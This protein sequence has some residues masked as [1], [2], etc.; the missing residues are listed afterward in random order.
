MYAGE[1]WLKNNKGA[2]YF[3]FSTVELDASFVADLAGTVCIFIG[4]LSFNNSSLYDAYWSAAPIFI[5]CYW[6]GDRGFDDLA[7]SPGF[8]RKC[9]VFMVMFVWGNRL[10]WNWA[11]SW[12]GFHH[13]DWRYVEVFQK[14]TKNYFRYWAESFGG[15]HLFPT[16]IVFAAMLP[17]YWVLHDH[18][19]EQV[20]PAEALCPISKIILR[21]FLKDFYVP[22]V[23]VVKPR[24][25][26]C[27]VPC[28]SIPPHKHD[29]EDHAFAVKPWAVRQVVKPSVPEPVTRNEDGRR[30]P[31]R[32]VKAGVVERQGT[33][34][35]THG[36][37]QVRN[38]G[39]VQFNSGKLKVSSTLVVLQPP[40][41]SIHRHGQCTRIRNQN[42]EQP[43]KLFPCGRRNHFLLMRIKFNLTTSFQTV[44]QG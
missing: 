14:G 5:A 4:S 22:P 10:T 21:S 15:I 29:H 25:R 2:G 20:N 34:E 26:P 31:V 3:E 17:S 13:E 9:M 32:V 41:T 36:A 37:C 23:L 40:F 8:Y 11:R 27:P 38:E 1:W 24:P 44:L 30:A 18:R 16:V 39:R 7:N 12:T 42:K 19:R 6:L 28:Q 33:D 35:N 43:V